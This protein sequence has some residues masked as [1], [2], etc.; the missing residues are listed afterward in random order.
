MRIVFLG[1]PGSGKGTQAKLMVETFGIPQIS[2]GDLLRAAVKAKSELGLKAQAAMQ[3]GELVSDDI[4]LG[5][6]KE[7]IQQPDAS[8]GYILDGFP[9]NVSQA[10]SLDTLLSELNQPLDNAILIDVPEEALLQRLLG[11]LTCASC[12]SVCNRFTSPPKVENVCDNCG[13]ELQHRSD[14]N[15]DT[16]RNRLTVY[17]EQT[18]P[19]IELYKKQGIFESI[20]GQKDINVIGAQLTELLT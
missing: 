7:R 11:R 8:K 4:V 20:D 12:G 1:A 17:Q 15:E 3:A 16:I 5:M 10:H 2:T 14:D 6:I 9:R 13:G 18:A 19:W